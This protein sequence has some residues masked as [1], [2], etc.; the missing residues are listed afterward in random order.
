MSSAT[1]G[2]IASNA[3]TTS[4]SAA[5]IFSPATCSSVFFLRSCVSFLNC[6]SLSALSPTFTRMSESSSASTLPTSSLKRFASFVL[7]AMNAFASLKRPVAFLRANSQFFSNSSAS[8]DGIPSRPFRK[9]SSA[10]SV[11]FIASV[12]ALRLSLATLMNSLLCHFSRCGRVADFTASTFATS[13]FLRA[14]RASSGA[15]ITAGAVWRTCSRPRTA[16][17][18]DSCASFIA[19]SIFSKAA[20]LSSPSPASASTLSTATS[21]APSFFDAS[22]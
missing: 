16:V 13:A 8:L 6:P 12:T 17:E 18:R 22:V 9:G 1:R 11:A 10:S 15:L 4:L 5:V 21:A 2:F 3:F 20:S 14:D 7:A 19:P